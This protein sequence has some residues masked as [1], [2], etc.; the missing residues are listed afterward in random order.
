[1]KKNIIYLTGFMGAGKSTIAPILANTLGWDNC[2]LDKV[3]EEKTGLKIKEIFESSGENEFRRIEAETLIELSSGDNII[4]SLGGGTICF[5]GNLSVAKSSGIIIYL[6][7]SVE[8]VY[9]RLI[10]KNDRPVLNLNEEEDLTKE[11]ALEKINQIYAV[12]KPY[13]EQADFIVETENIPIGRTVDHLARLIK[14]HFKGKNIEE[15]N[16]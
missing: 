14:T 7:T 9:N 2:D 12:R 15:S 6:K 11:S 16:S 1:M 5:S 3:I 4:I 13:Y 10:Y 8:A